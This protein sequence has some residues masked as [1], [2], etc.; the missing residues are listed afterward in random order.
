MSGGRL[1]AEDLVS[2]SETMQ[3][4]PLLHKRLSLSFSLSLSLSFSFLLFFLSFYF[5]D[6]FL[7]TCRRGKYHFS[8]FEDCY[9]FELFD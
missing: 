8:L 2:V 7:S 5:L 3:L 9:S 1:E 6:V 4:K